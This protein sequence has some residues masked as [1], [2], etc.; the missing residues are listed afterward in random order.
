MQ[1]LIYLEMDDFLA[2]Q[3]VGVTLVPSSREVCFSEAV[4][5]SCVVCLLEAVVVL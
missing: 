5:S 1:N 3:V 2:A 4:C